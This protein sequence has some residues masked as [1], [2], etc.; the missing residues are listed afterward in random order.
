[1]VEI[2]QAIALTYSVLLNIY[3]HSYFPLSVIPK[4]LTK[5]PDFL[6]KSGFFCSLDVAKQPNIF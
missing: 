2:E 6:E 4:Y 3:S 1:M 5:N